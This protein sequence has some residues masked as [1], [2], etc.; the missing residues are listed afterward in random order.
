V[1]VEADAAGSLGPYC[2]YYGFSETAPAPVRRRE[3]PGA[4]VVAVVS[5]GEPWWINGERVVSFA[6]G[7]HERQVITEHRGRSFA[8]QLNIAPP[9]A[10]V[11][12]GLPLHT[13]ANRVVPLDEVLGGRDLGERVHDSGDWHARFR[14]LDELLLRRLT[15]GQRPDAGVWWAW[16][17]LE[18]SH[19]RAAIGALAAELGWSRKRIVARFR[20]QIGLAPKTYARLLRFEHALSLAQRAE[21]PDWGRIAFQSGYYDQSHLIHDFRDISGHTPE[22]F[23]QDAVV[24]SP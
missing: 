8:I 1:L 11:L 2:R 19:G 14:V 21:R 17:R 12:L 7:L 6:A 13:L 22:T 9:V 24:A 16:R 10:H 3:G 23:F 20:E 15:D 4:D 5:F 18:K